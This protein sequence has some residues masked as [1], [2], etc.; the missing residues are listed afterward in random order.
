MFEVEETIALRQ[1]AQIGSEFCPQC[2]LVSALIMPRVIAIFS[3]VKE[4]EIFRLIESGKIY[5]VEANGVLVCLSC[6]YR[7]GCDYAI[8]RNSSGP[9]SGLQ[10]KK[11][12]T[13]VKNVETKTIRTRIRSLF[14]GSIAMTFLLVAS[15]FVLTGKEVSDVESEQMIAAF[16]DTMGSTPQF[17]SMSPR[18]KQILYESAVVTGG[19][20]ALLHSQGAEQKDAAMQSDARNMSIA[21]VKHFLESMRDRP[22]IRPLA[23]LINGNSHAK[24]PIQI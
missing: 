13:E 5:F 10:T 21:V 4:R 16:N 8:T 9:E 1:G 11:E 12:E 14:L 17:V 18:D 22:L 3:G 19:M 2:R 15:L 6:I 23:S 7:Y 24:H 20:I